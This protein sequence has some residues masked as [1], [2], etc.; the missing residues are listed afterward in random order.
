MKNLSQ[1]QLF[2]SET[3]KKEWHKIEEIGAPAKLAT[4][5]VHPASTVPPAACSPAF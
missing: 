3:K 4:A 2:R 1:T 5:T